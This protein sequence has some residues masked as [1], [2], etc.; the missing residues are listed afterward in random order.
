MFQM[1][2]PGP[3]WVTYTELAQKGYVLSDSSGGKRLGSQ[4]LACYQRPSGTTVFQVF[5]RLQLPAVAMTKADWNFGLFPYGPSWRAHRRAFHQQMNQKAVSQYRPT[6]RLHTTKFLR[7]LLKD[8]GNVLDDTQTLFG[9]IIL[10]MAYGIRDEKYIKDFTILAEKQIQGIAS[11]LVPGRFLVNTLPFLRF[12]PSWFPGAGWKKMFQ[13]LAEVNN[14]AEAPNQEEVIQNVAAIAYIAGAV[15]TIGTASGLILALAMY[16]DAQ[17]RAQGE[18]DTVVGPS[19]LPDFDD[20]PHLPYLQALVNEV[21]R[22]WPVAPLALPHTTSEDDVYKDYFI[23]R[24]TVVF[25]N[26]WA[27]SRDPIIYPNPY[28]FRPERFLKD[29][30]IDPD[31]LDPNSYAFGF[32]R[33]ICPGRWLSQESLGLFA[34]SL[35]AVFNVL[36]AKD[37]TGSPIP[38]KYEP[39]GTMILKPERFEC[40]ITPRSAAHAS[41]V[42]EE[43]QGANLQGS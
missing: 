37:E 29:G 11:A 42:R 41:L 4:L 28:E 7:H 25:G 5:D 43:Q 40:R 24:G 13:E 20:F 1:A 6:I 38:L 9:Q 3:L 36:P 33:R 35:L 21:A 22:L 26:S 15:T 34:A 14:G 17:R 32:G 2:K 10:H 12:V 18:I 23:P 19:R 27:I 31:V 39:N 30:K 16:P 8:P